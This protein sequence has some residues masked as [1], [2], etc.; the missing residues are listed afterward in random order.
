MFTKEKEMES[1]EE[2]LKT[3]LDMDRCSLW[4]GVEMNDKVRPFL[5]LE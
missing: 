5:L 2:M 1:V 4:T 3:N